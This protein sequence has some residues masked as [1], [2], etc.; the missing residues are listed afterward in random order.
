VLEAGQ[1]W[2]EFL[3]AEKLSED[4]LRRNLL[5]E[6]T[7]KRYLKIR[8]TDEE[9][10]ELYKSRRREFDGTELRIQHILLTGPR[11]TWAERDELRNRLWSIR[12]DI[13]FERLTFNEAVQKHSQAADASQQGDLGFIGRWGPMPEEFSNEAFSLP[14]D[15]IG[16]PVESMHGMHL[17]KVVEEKPGKLTWKDVKDRVRSFAEQELHT[18][19]LET[20]LDAVIEYTGAYPYF[21]RRDGKLVMPEQAEEVQ[22]RE[23]VLAQHGPFSIMMPEYCSPEASGLVLGKD[24]FSVTRFMCYEDDIH[25]EMEI[26]TPE[27]GKP[28]VPNAND[29]LLGLMQASVEDSGLVG[30]RSGGKLVRSNRDDVQ[31]FPAVT[32]EMKI[33]HH[34]PKGELPYVVH[35][36]IVQMRE[37][38]VQLVVKGHPDK[39]LI[40]HALNFWKT[41]KIAD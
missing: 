5:F 30:E 17:I 31:G 10:Q 35:Q 26:T 23:G 18:S 24:R 4:D 25:Y 7:W 28:F 37:H 13:T 32:F 34:T 6:E 27:S 3:Y 12:G 14:A 9:L 19:I 21:D 1:T 15:I 22:A 8:L 36:R 41:F 38:T 16:R 11:E 29:Y 2:E 20:S 33:V 40:T 39:V